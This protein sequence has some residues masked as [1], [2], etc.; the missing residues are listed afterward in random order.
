M[1]DKDFEIL[2]MENQSYAKIEYEK[3]LKSGMFFEFFPL[4]SGN[5]E[6]DK[7]Q[8]VKTRLKDSIDL[9]NAKKSELKFIIQPKMGK[10]YIDENRVESIRKDIKRLSKLVDGFKSW[11]WNLILKLTYFVY[12]EH[13]SIFVI[14]I[15]LIW[16]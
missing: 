6:K 5:W 8:Y 14:I 9:L 13:Y 3:C 15:Y 16:I 11:E 1:I 10:H 2:M 12:I 4:L 7:D